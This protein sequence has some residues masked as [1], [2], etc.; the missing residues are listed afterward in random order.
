AF[1]CRQTGM[2]VGNCAIK[3]PGSSSG[4]NE[5]RRTSSLVEQ[6]NAKGISADVAS[7]QRERPRTGGVKKIGVTNTSEGETDRCAGNAA[8]SID[9][10]RRT[11]DD[12]DLPVR[13][14]RRGAGVLQ[15]SAVN[16][17]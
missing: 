13:A 4:L 7:G 16:V 2:C 12:A 17:N 10:W 6:R 11:I 14:L 3:N 1:D 5:A 8:R 15:S 9:R